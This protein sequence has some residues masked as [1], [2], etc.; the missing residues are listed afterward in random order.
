MRNCWG[1]Y[2]N[3]RENVSSR[4]DYILTRENQPRC[5]PNTT[6]K[7]SWLVKG[8]P[9]YPREHVT[10][11]WVSTKWNTS[12]LWVAIKFSIHIVIRVVK[13]LSHKWLL[14]IFTTPGIEDR[15]FINIIVLP[16]FQVHCEARKGMLNENY[17]ACGY[18]AH[19][20]TTPGRGGGNSCPSHR[21]QPML[22]SFMT[23]VSIQ[24]SSP[25]MSWPDPTS[26]P[27]TSLSPNDSFCG[28]LIPMKVSILIILICQK[29]VNLP[30]LFLTP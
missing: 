13:V 2:S 12:K 10:D 29:E 8:K 25:H 19:L 23:P 9:R 27:Q 1:R 6:N 30:P 5:Q 16:I 15:Y 11:K 17:H 18:S 14:W 7:E 21:R 3:S 22:W 20:E 4:Q 28:Q 26:D 24:W